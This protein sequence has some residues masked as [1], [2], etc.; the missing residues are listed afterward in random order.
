MDIVYIE[1][2]NWF[3]GR[4][5][6]LG[7][8]YETWIGKR[9]FSDD[10]WCKENNICV[11]GGEYDMSENWCIT[12]TK[13][14]VLKNCPELLSGGSYTYKMLI[15]YKGATT[16]RYCVRKYSDFLRK[17]DK[18]G[19]VEGMFGWPFLDYD[20]HN[21]GSHY[22]RDTSFDYVDDDEYDDDE[23][24]FKSEVLEEND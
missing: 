19:D 20:E 23:T 13:D 17:P 6:P 1:F 10:A 9:M 11:N 3:A 8:P 16:E 14:W 4:D 21:F 18:Y 7:E 24:V 12:A 15:H 5:Y 22:Y 2:N